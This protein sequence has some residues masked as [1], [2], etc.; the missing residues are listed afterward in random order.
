[1]THAQ[2]SY[3][4]LMESGPP[5]PHR[6]GPARPAERRGSSGRRMPE[7][8][9]PWPRPL[10]GALGQAQEGSAAAQHRPQAC[11]SPCGAGTGQLLQVCLRRSRRSWGPKTRVRHQRGERSRVADEELP[12]GLLGPGSPPCMPG[13]AGGSTGASFTTPWRVGFR[14]GNYRGNPRKLQTPK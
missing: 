4:G 8:A 3:L 7:R 2:F 11:L 14:E 13:R 10:A 9:W 6:S 5:R 1:M 12:E